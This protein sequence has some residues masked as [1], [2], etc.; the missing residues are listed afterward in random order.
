[1]LTLW[2][3]SACADCYQIYAS[4][5]LSGQSLCRN[6]AGTAFPLFTRQ[7][8]NRLGYQWASFL[9][10]CLGFALSVVPFI[11][12]AYGPKIR[13]RSRFAKELAAM[14]GKQ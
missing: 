5:A 7:M 1:M 10:G 13:A 9:A 2:R 6:L 8:Y 12:Y 11:L 4:S 14:Q 3:R